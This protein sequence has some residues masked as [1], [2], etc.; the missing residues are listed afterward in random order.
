MSEA[1]ALAWCARRTASEVVGERPEEADLW[2]I[3]GERN[4]LSA[5]WALEGLRKIGRGDV[6]FVTTDILGP[7]ARW[8]HWITSSSVG[9]A[10]DL[11]DGRT[12]RSTSVTGVLNRLW[13]P[14]GW[15]IS[16]RVSPTD[17]IYATEEISAFFLSWL[18]SFPG[19]VI[20]RP[21]PSCFSGQERHPAEWYL[22]AGRAGIT[23]PPYRQSSRQPAPQS[24]GTITREDS[25][26]LVLDGEPFGL[27]PPLVLAA[28]Q[29]LAN[30]CGTRLLGITLSRDQFDSWNFVGASTFPDMRLGGPL[31]ID[32]LADAF[33]AGR[34]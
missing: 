25:T 9:V 32:A 34:R 10:I 20:N 21:T 30:M 11:P 28:C 18:S 12:I 8:N 16:S 33:E 24:A 14:S 1:A 6:E 5:H 27:A 17:R 26:V 13:R 2:L 7:G 19:S 31:L 22:L 15:R 23:T 29:R 4:D 3:I